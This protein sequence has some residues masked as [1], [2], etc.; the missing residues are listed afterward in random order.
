M[1]DH[2]ARFREK[3]R[4]TSQARYKGVWKFDETLSPLPL[5]NG[6]KYCVTFN[7]RML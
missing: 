4:F 2:H 5:V 6:L 3:W 1:I 7:C